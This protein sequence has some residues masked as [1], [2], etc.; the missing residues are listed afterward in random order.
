MEP[1]IKVLEE[2]SQYLNREWFVFG[3]MGLKLKGLNVEPDDVDIWT[4][5]E[6]AEKL[7]EAFSDKLVKTTEVGNGPTSDVDVYQIN[8][9]ELEVL[10]G[11]QYIDFTETEETQGFP[12]PKDQAFAEMYQIIGEEEK[13][14]KLT[15]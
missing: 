11:N 15:S 8:G 2:V 3:S 14:E 4:T 12:V 13:A 9:E 6:N 7:R 10:Y 5:D 1:K